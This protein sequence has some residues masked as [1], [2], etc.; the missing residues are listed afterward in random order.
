M[1]IIEEKNILGES[2][3]WNY[4]N[5]KFYWVD[6][7]DKKIKSYNGNIIENYETNKMP[8]CITL[9]DNNNFTLA[10]EDEIGIYDIRNGSFN[11]QFKLEDKRVRFNDGKLDKYGVL[12]IGTMDRDANEHIGQIYKYE[13]NYLEPIIKNVGISNGISFDSNNKMYWSD[14]LDRKLYYENELIK[15]YEDM[16]PDGAYINEKDEY[17]S[18][19]W[20]GSRIDIY[21][22]KKIYDN[23]V[24]PVEYPTCCCCGG[25][26]MNKLFVTSAS[27]L[28]KEKENGKCIIIDNI[29]F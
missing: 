25:N 23:I 7:I 27:V 17:Y 20:G 16:T 10:L 12:H 13:N 21:R 24:L 3:L 8:C 1:N 26:D 11:S 5:N 9:L 4:Y 19:L 15:E 22:D 29:K 14:S 2:C 6:I 28:N 18:C